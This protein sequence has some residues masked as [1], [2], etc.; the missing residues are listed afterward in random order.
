MLNQQT[1]ENI[2]A[3]AWLARIERMTLEELAAFQSSVM[4]EIL[5]GNITP[6]ESRIIDRAVGKRLKAIEQELR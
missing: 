3:D 2:D 1:R 5:N 6:R 4:T